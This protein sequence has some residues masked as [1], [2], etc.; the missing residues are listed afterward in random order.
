VSNTATA[1]RPEVAGRRRAVVG[2]ASLGVALFVAVGLLG[3]ER[4]AWN[5]WLYRGF[6][7]PRDPAYVTVRGTTEKIGVVSPALGGRTQTAYVY[8]PPGY[9]AHPHRRYPVL[10]L[11]HG[12]P[13][14][15]LAFLL[16]VRMGVLE[17]ALAARHRIRPPILVMPYGSTGTFTDKEWANGIHPGEGWETFVA[18]DLVRAID[19]KFRTIPAGRGR[20]LAGLSEGGYGAL[21]IGLH[22]PG[23]F[24]VLESWSGYARA[25]N[26]HAIFGGSPA[27]LARNTPLTTLARAAP[28]LRRA[29][30]YVWFYSGRQDPLRVQNDAF[31]KELTLLNVAHRFLVVP[32]GHNWAVWRTHAQQALVA[33]SRRLAHA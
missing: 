26:V 24:R 3:V 19:K 11:M 28:A 5:Y 8:L 15:P 17:D 10:Y 14:R 7:A 25:D 6:A 32:G 31:A 30:T 9:A 27:L 12:F 33:A 2:L 1:L 29:H 18:R 4:Y 13:G 21:N 20:A 22:H 16:T 23:E